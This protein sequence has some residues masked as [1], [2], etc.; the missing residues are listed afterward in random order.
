MLCV[1]TFPHFYIL[2]CLRDSAYLLSYGFTGFIESTTSRMSSLSNRNADNTRSVTTFFK[3]NRNKL[4]IAYLATIFLLVNAL[5]RVGLY[6]E[7]KYFL[8]TIFI[9]PQFSRLT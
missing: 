1:F 2:S 9:L 5:S 4:V 3:L 6:R 8:L 7:V